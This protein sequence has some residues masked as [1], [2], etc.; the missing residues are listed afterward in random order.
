[1]AAALLKY[2]PVVGWSC[3]AFER[4]NGMMGAIKNN[5]HAIETTF[6]KSWTELDLLF[7][8]PFLTGGW[9]TYSLG[10]KAHHHALHGVSSTPRASALS[11]MDQ[12]LCDRS[13]SRVFVHATCVRA[14]VEPWR[15]QR[16]A[17]AAD[18]AA[19][20]HLSWIPPALV[21]TGAEPF[22][23]DVQLNDL[24]RRRTM[25]K[26]DSKATGRADTIAH[27]GLL[28]YFKETYGA[29]DAPVDPAA[30]AAAAAAAALASAPPAADTAPGMMDGVAGAG[31]WAPFR[32]WA[33]D[34]DCPRSSR[35]QFF[36]D[37][38]G[39]RLSRQQRA[40]WV[41]VLSGSRV[42]PAQCLQFAR[43]TLIITHHDGTIERR[44]HLLVRLR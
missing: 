34:M 5:S 41:M 6:M 44:I 36:S 19:A 32:S 28:R 8:L 25:L 42:V 23:G 24:Q 29:P 27:Q 35:L 15:R 31:R 37:E 33:L 14:E 17:A 30:A 40:S 26:P 18:A 2:G 3:W 9:T 11:I 7:V 39:T 20:P 12:L 22:V 38:L 13:R 43:P 4:Y 1:M 10:E 16:A 21:L